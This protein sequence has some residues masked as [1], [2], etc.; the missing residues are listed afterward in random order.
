M[1]RSLLGIVL[2]IASIGLFVSGFWLFWHA[3][4]GR[5]IILHLFFALC[6]LTVVLLH[7]LNNIKLLK[8]YI[9]KRKVAFVVVLALTALFVS[10]SNMP[11]AEHLIRG[12]A[13]LQQHTPMQKDRSITVYELDEDP[14]LSIELRA[15]PHFWFPQVAI[16][17]ADTSGHHLKTLF[18]THSTAKGEFYG[19]RTKENFKSFDGDIQRGIEIRRVD[20]LPHWSRQYGMK[21]PD[22]LYAPTTDFPLPDGLSGATS[23]GSML[24]HSAIESNEPY[25]L[26]VELN[27]AFDDNRFY[28]AY[29][30]PEDTL[31]HNGTGLMGQPSVVYAATIFPDNQTKNYLLAY[32]GHTHPTQYGPLISDT[33]GLTTALEILDLGLVIVH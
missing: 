23:D 17:I 10:A 12:Y 16:W 24:L 26:K 8:G 31:Y 22:G 30:F 11:I 18:V 27:V 14:N 15:G 9:R 2:L 13:R 28:S 33:K 5:L 4:D 19:G 29:D 7:V 1:K 25:R 6:F 32:E 20:A 3:S 21:A